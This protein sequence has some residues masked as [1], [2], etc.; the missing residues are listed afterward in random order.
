MM[1]K[2]VLLRKTNHQECLRAL[3]EP[4]I[5]PMVGPSLRSLGHGLGGRREVSNSS[6][7]PQHEDYNLLSSM[8]WIVLIL[9]A[10]C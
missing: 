4:R 5:L 8:L 2:V 10:W 7:A 1:D 9:Q 6:E 3:P